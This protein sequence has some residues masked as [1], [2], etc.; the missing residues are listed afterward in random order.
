MVQTALRWYDA[1]AD[2]INS[3]D[4]LIK[5]WVGL[6]ALYGQDRQDLRFRVAL[7]GAVYLS[8]ASPNNT[9][10]RDFEL[11]YESY[12]DRSDIMHGAKTRPDVPRRADQTVDALRRTLL[13]HVPAGEAWSH[14]DKLDDDII[15]RLADSGS[16]RGVEFP[17]S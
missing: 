3:S 7:R 5:A 17:S 6:E 2:E 9:L 10:R 12:R 13:A 1:A 4:R 11:L 14:G 16:S 8:K 15:G